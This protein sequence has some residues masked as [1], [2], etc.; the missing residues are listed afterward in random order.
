MG[1]STWWGQ[2]VIQDLSGEQSCEG[3]MGSIGGGEVQWQGDQ[4]RTGCRDCAEELG[5]QLLSSREPL[6]SMNSRAYILN[7]VL[8][9]RF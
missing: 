3:K 4:I 2:G 1:I 7:C 8:E 9:R 5:L 6:R